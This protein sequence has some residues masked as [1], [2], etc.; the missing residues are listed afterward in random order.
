MQHIAKTHLA[1]LATC[2][3]VVLC[4]FTVLG[5]VPHTLFRPLSFSP[6]AFASLKMVPSKLS[7][8]TNTEARTGRGPGR[9]QIE[10]NM[11]FP[12]ACQNEDCALLMSGL[13]EAATVK[14]DG[15]LLAEAGV[16]PRVIPRPEDFPMMASIPRSLHPKSD[17]LVEI[18]VFCK[19]ACSEISK[20]ALVQIVRRDD[21]F[22]FVRAN[23]VRFAFLPIACSMGLICIS[24]IACV[25]LLSGRQQRAFGIFLV[26]HC[27]A[28]GVAYFLFADVL[29]ESLPMRFAGPVY[30]SLRNIGNLAFFA[31]SLASLRFTGWPKKL[32]H[33]GFLLAAAG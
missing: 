5:F 6:T 12:Q 31:L 20:N 32:T 23:T 7:A 1:V 8:S 16:F 3:L 9:V 27:I 15:H 28:N 2:I 18:D 17:H 26:V 29:Y 4:A 10:S 19:K 11:P 13:G 25:F 30:L 14:I 24:L 33:L 22:S 21:A